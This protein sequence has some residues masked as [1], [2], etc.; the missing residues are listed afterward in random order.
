MSEYTG[1]TTSSASERPERGEAVLTLTIAQNMLFLVRKIVDDLVGS[2]QRLCKLQLEEDRLQR[3]RH[4]LTWPERARRYEIQ[5]DLA[6]QQQNVEEALAEIEYLGLTL[7][8]VSEGRIG[9]PTMVNG[10][11]AFF[12]WRRGEE[13]F[14][15]WHFASETALRPIP[16]AWCEP[17]EK[18]VGSK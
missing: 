6:V 4:H 8:D 10:R 3:R 15:H 5:E 13:G 7:L 17:I 14:R 2:R 12:S 16:A 11:R 9:F 18:G 1:D